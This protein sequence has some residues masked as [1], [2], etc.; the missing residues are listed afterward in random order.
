MGWSLQFRSLVNC[1][2]YRKESCDDRGDVSRWLGD[3]AGGRGVTAARV[4]VPGDAGRRVP[5]S[6]WRGVR[7]L[8]RGPGPAVP[9]WLLLP[10]FLGF[11]F[12]IMPLVALTDAVDWSHFFSLVTSAS[13]R[14]ALWLS[15]KTALASTVLCV[16]LG[17]PMAVLLARVRWRVLPLF[18]AMVL[19]PLVLPPVVGGL[20]LLYLFGRYGLLGRRLEAMGIDVAFSTTAVVL[21]ETF[22]ALPFLV[23]TLEGAMRTAGDRY[24]RIA[25]TLGAAPT[26]VWLRITLPLLR[27]ALVSG[28]VL[29]FARALG[30]FGATITFAGSLQGR[31]RTLPLEI[32][33]QRENDPGAAVA[34]SLLLVVIA[35]LIVL[36]AYRRVGVPEGREWAGGLWRWGGS[37][38]AAS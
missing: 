8:L 26:T 36:V 23:I 17:V 21:A 27:P 5:D 14:D 1:D 38:R 20:S 3:P 33:L 31:T 37:G 19:L 13:S 25:A 24:E 7:A 34:L 9:R 15:V 35:V 32:Y 10:A 4:R 11:A 16:V 22:V 18:R 29:A 30:E 2:V 6:A 12:V 28:A